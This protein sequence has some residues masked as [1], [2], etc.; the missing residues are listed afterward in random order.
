MITRPFPRIPNLALRRARQSMRLSQAQFAEAVRAAGNAIGVPNHCTKRLVQ[1]WESGEHA[2][3]RPDYLRVLQAVT[4]LSARELG[5]RVLPGESG[6]NAA[7][8]DAVAEGTADE[9][10]RNASTAGAD[11]AAFAMSGPT[12]YDAD[13]MIEGS[14]DRVRRALENPSTVDSRTAGFVETATAR[15]FD[16]Q[17]HSPSRLLA[18]TVG[19]HL[20]TVTRLLT[21]AQR[22][23]VRRRLMVSA[24]RSALLA[25][26][27]AFD[28]GDTPTSN[29]LW[30]TSISAAEGTLDA[31]VL[32]ASLTCLSY[33]AARRGD[34]G[35][36]WQLAHAAGQHTRDDPRAA[37]WALS[38]VALYAAQ[39]GER[40]AAHAAMD[41]S[42]ELG[43]GLPNPRPG[44][45]GTPWM[46]FFD[47]AKLLSSTART[48]AILKDPSAADYA[49]K[50]VDALGPAKVKARAVVL[51]EASLTAAIV[52][53][54]ELCLDY[55]SAAA[56]LTRELNV[57]VAADILYEVVPLVLPYS[58]TR[59]VRE[60]LPQLTRLTRTAD[61]EDELEHRPEVHPAAVG[62]L[63]PGY[64]ATGG[65]VPVPEAAPDIP[66]SQE[67]GCT[68]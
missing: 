17:C 1:K 4:G 7:A 30:D 8:D 49:A 54:L 40:E 15:L 3:C 44:D 65:Q 10:S 47:L 55:G 32:A 37:S 16:L 14:M 51:A 33:S 62:D 23:G 22:E 58:D 64:P 29:R 34:T 61:R 20:S 53:E 57:S 56:T 36:A 9:D 2:A 48:A 43:G 39:L 13:S 41:R 66:R 19:R 67:D 25:G 63:A 50:A 26:W 24:G 38:R 5:F 6:M 35:T 27:L 68:S 59:T 11:E 60:L 21:A 28:R 52:G 45:G 18:P 42:L 31:A 12:E 46:R